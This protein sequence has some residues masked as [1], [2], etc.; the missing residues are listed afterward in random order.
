MKRILPL[1][2]LAC[3]LLP[4][5]E[6]FDLEN[7]T[8]TPENPGGSEVPGGPDGPDG[9]VG[10][11]GP[12]GPDGPDNPDNPPSVPF[13]FDEDL[14]S[15]LFGPA[16]ESVAVFTNSN[17]GDWTVSSDQTWCSVV[18]LMGE[19]PFKIFVSVETYLESEGTV[20]RHATITVQDDTG[21]L[22]TLAVTQDP[23]PEITLPPV[24]LVPASG[25]TMRIPIHTNVSKIG[26]Y[27]GVPQYEEYDY[28]QSWI[29]VQ[30][31]EG[32]TV[33]VIV[34]PWD[35]SQ[36]KPLP[37]CVRVYAYDSP[38]EHLRLEYGDPSLSGEDFPYF[39]ETPWD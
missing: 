8:E 13:A 15:L 10:P 9:P 21:T 14:S 11:E 19:R 27:P 12:D 39:D 34:A 16:E 33:V 18:K 17:E 32:T 38:A 29:Q 31:C 2:L 1:A 35:I 5:C 37:A 20:P 30:D 22:A 28:D 25:G 7:N 4:A 23:V 26:A 3:L 6:P 24:V 36:P